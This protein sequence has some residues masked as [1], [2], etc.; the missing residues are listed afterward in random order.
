MQGRYINHQALKA[1]GGRERISMITSFRPKSADVKD[2][3]VLTGVR[4]I[5]NL[6]ELY[7]DYTQYR[8]ELLEDRFREQARQQRQRVVEGKRFDT[9]DVKEFL[10]QQKDYIETTLNELVEQLIKYM[11]TTT[12]NLLASGASY[13]CVLK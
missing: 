10:R 11:S 12:L 13:T 3:S 5:S 7:S 1:L 4:G 2:E 8:L 9:R 6:N